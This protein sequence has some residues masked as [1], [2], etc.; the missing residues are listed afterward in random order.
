MKS[1][2]NNEKTHVDQCPHNGHS[3]G[4]TVMSETI[5]LL[6]VDIAPV[7]KKWLLNETLYNTHL[8]VFQMLLLGL[9]LCCG[10][11][12]VHALKPNLVVC[13]VARIASGTS[14]AIVY[15]T[16]LVKLVFLVSL[17]GG[18][19]L[20]ATY[21]SLLLCFAILIQVST[22]LVYMCSSLL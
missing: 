4:W 2:L 5:V 10:S 15:A 7:S 14:Y 8:Y 21:Q 13:S 18:V 16:L 20:P 22:R 3:V 17:N 1:Y 6:G 9:I 19:Y 11:A 12:V